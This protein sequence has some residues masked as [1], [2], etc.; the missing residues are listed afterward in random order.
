[1][2]RYATVDEMDENCYI[3][4]SLDSKGVLR[5]NFSN[6]DL[7]SRRLE[8][9]GAYVSEGHQTSDLDAITG[10]DSSN[11]NLKEMELEPGSPEAKLDSF[12]EVYGLAI[13]S[14]RESL[15]SAMLQDLSPEQKKEYIGDAIRFAID[16]KNSYENMLDLVDDLPVEYRFKHFPEL[17]NDL[18][19]LLEELNQ[20]VNGGN[21][22]IF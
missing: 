10:D 21:D 12:L 17:A 15:E 9:I 16:A 4:D 19:K 11:Y 7:V 5:G 18:T 22:H 2:V 14:S 3:P 20:L 8:P 6:P 1:M 13:M